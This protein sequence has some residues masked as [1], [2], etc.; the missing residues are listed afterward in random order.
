MDNNDFELTIA[1]VVKKYGLLD[2]KRHSKSLGQHFLCDESLLRKIVSC[3]LPL[4]NNDVVEI[5]PGPGGL[6]RAIIKFI[7]KGS[8][9]CIEKDSSLKPVHDNLLKN[10]IA[11]LNFVYGDGLAIKPQSLT[12]KKVTIISNL[13]YNVGTQI[14]I[15]WLG[16]L[17]DIE[18]MVLMFQK[19][20]ADRI[21]AKPGT[22]NYGRLSI[23]SQLLCKTEK[24]FDISNSAFFPPPKVVSTVIKLTPRN[25]SLSNISDLEK[26]TA[27]CFQQ[28]RKTIFSILKKTYP[29]DLE[30]IL[31]S[32]SI[33][34]MARPE[35]IS[36]EQFL[37]LSKKLGDA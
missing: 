33:D 35:T 18:K 36:P 8:I 11:N 22:K 34:K 4:E 26:L 3:A 23:I 14:L 30:K 6:T 37:E 24:V 29:N 27:L 16:D 32:C 25:G 28:R 15:N 9:F 20:V 13:P 2:N 31:N 12:S 5:G 17:S 1:Q 19:E 21:C 10:S 7:G